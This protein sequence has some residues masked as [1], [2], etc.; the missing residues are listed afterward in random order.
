MYHE[1]IANIML[2][3]EKLKPFLVRSEIRQQCP[4]L[5]LLSN[6]VLK[7]LVRSIRQEKEIKGIQIRKEEVK[8]SLIAGDM[9]LYIEHPK[10]PNK[11]LLEQ[12]NK[13]SKV[14]VDKTNIQIQL[15]FYTLKLS[16]KNRN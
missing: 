1:P 15:H 12:I 14:A 4:L 9:I 16:I 8:L 7:I 2:Y 11:K 13:C 5:P 6:I 3:C 10:D